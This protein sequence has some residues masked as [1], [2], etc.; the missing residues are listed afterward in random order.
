MAKALYFLTHEERPE[1][2]SGYG[3][4]LNEGD[5]SSLVGMLMVDRPERVAPEYL[6]RI[7]NTFG[8]F[9]LG[10]MTSNGDRGLYTRMR[11]DDPISLELVRDGLYNSVAGVIASVRWGRWF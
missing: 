5:K 1:M 6:D 10:P 9:Q 7:Y 3:I 11:I 8:E 4:P 2:F